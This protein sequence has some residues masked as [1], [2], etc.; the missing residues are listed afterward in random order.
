MQAVVF[1]VCVP[2]LNWPLPWRLEKSPALL[3]LRRLTLVCS[4][5][6]QVSAA[7]KANT[8]RP[9]YHLLAV[10]PTTEE[11]FR[12]ACEKAGFWDPGPGARGWVEDWRFGGLEV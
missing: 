6:A 5:V 9:W 2:S 10:R 11:A 7:E 8:L 4:E 1:L 3:Q 12:A